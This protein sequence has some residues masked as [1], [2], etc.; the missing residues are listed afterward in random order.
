MACLL[1]LEN[2]WFLSPSCVFHQDAPSHNWSVLQF[3]LRSTIGH[4]QQHDQLMHAAHCA[5]SLRS[6]HSQDDRNWCNT[7]YVCQTSL[8]AQYA[9]PYRQVPG[10]LCLL[11][12]HAHINANM[13]LLQVTATAT[14]TTTATW[15]MQMKLHH[16]TPCSVAVVAIIAIKA[17]IKSSQS[18]KQMVCW[19]IFQQ[20]ALR[21]RLVK[22][23]Q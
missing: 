22:A 21:L 5:A 19:L 23:S 3:S 1:S 6:L 2:R 20:I 12:M 13:C 9:R 17:L 8:C 16:S 18:I 14:A 15:R 10:W 4:V 7:A 11:W